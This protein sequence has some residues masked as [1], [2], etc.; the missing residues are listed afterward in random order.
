MVTYGDMHLPV[1]NISN[2]FFDDRVSESDAC[3][4]PV[5]HLPVIFIC[6]NVRVPG[7]SS[8]GRIWKSGIDNVEFQFD[9]TS[10][11]I[12]FNDTTRPSAV[13][14]VGVLLLLIQNVQDSIEIWVCL[15][16]WNGKI[17]NIKLFWITSQSF[18]AL[19]PFYK[20]GN[21]FDS[22]LI[23]YIFVVPR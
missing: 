21:Q 15:F 13:P 19:W 17:E 4:E 6:I 2:V 16:Y 7:D 14:D 3:P 8:R 11:Q 12:D 9:I 10:L 1:S 20:Q 22:F 23:W 18:R 5:G